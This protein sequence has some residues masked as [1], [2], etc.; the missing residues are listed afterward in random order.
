MTF[1]SKEEEVLSVKWK[2]VADLHLIFT[3]VKSRFSHDAAH[4]LC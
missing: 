4:F 2:K 1:G 3:K